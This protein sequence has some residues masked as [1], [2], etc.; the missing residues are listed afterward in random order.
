MDPG[1]G[2]VVVS[3]SELMCGLIDK[4]IVGSGSKQNLIHILLREYGP[5]VVSNR[6]SNLAKVC[7]RW[8]GNF[9]FSI[10]IDDVAP[11]MKLKERKRELID[12]GFDRCQ[13]AIEQ[14]RR[15]RINAS[16]LENNLQQELSMVRETAGSA[17][18]AE[19]PRDNSALIMA[20]SGSK[21]SALNISQM[22]ALVGQQILMGSRMPNGFRCAIVPVLL[23]VAAPLTPVRCAVI[24]RC[25]TLRFPRRMS[26]PRA[27]LSRARS[28]R[29][30]AQQSSSS[31]PWLGA[32]AWWTRQ[33]RCDKAWRVCVVVELLTPAQFR[34]RRRATCSGA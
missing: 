3:D 2:Y 25:R 8:L 31:T 21:G 28:S 30:L 23:G 9:G 20:V 27:A 29:A 5:A 12:A 19:L 32:K 17:C 34:R 13:G 18:L 22:V 24:A 11:S 16:D 26:R 10:G 14:H 15:N 6:L 4:K 33:S 7:A 1:D